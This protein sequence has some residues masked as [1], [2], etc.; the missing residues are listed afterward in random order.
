MCSSPFK[1]F[2]ELTTKHLVQFNKHLQFCRN[3]SSSSTYIPTLTQQTNPI[4][5]FTHNSN[6]ISF[7]IWPD[8]SNKDFHVL[9]FNLLI[10]SISF[11]HRQ[12]TH[13]PIWF[14]THSHIKILPTI[15][16]L[17]FSLP[18][19]NIQ[20]VYLTNSLFYHHFSYMYIV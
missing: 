15:S 18:T 20:F 12:P 7:Y 11:S 10:I 19:R 17:N 3:H 6:I 13:D 4:S 8:P 1:Y 16:Q 5:Q 14:P 9:S 2:S